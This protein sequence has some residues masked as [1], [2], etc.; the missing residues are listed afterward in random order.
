MNLI[1][2]TETTGFPSEKL[3]ANHPKQAHLVAIAADLVTDT[4]ETVMSMNFIVNSGAS[5]AEGALKVHGLT[6]GYCQA[7]GLP[8]AEAVRTFLW[9]SD[10]ATTL[11]AHNVGFDLR[12]MELAAERLSGRPI[13]FFDRRKFCTMQVAKKRLGFGKL[14]DVHRELI[15]HDFDGAHNAAADKDAC[16]RIYFA[17]KARGE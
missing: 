2:D 4:E 15:G 13:D 11:V 10:K 17:L 1:F 14:A 3:V 9:L 5:S 8:E 16:R 6:D 12:I 7:M